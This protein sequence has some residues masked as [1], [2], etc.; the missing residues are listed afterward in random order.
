MTIPAFV[1]VPPGYTFNPGYEY[2]FQISDTNI[3]V[4]NTNGNSVNILNKAFTV[5]ITYEE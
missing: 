4:I 3:V 5:L 2:Q 1:N